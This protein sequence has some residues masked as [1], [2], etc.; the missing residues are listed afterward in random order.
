MLLIPISLH[1]NEILMATKLTAWR[2]RINE[3][4][5]TLRITNK[6]LFVYSL[7]S[8]HLIA[9]RNFRDS[10]ISEINELRFIFFNFVSFSLFIRWRRKS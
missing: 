6:N 8:S 9:I 1:Y 10:V 4:K 5:Q 7:S 2:L 3:Y